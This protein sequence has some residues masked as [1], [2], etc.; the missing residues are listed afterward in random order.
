MNY[1]VNRRI[2]GENRVE[3]GLSSDIYRFKRRCA[4]TEQVN[5]LEDFLLLFAIVAIVD[6]H[7]I[8]A[9]LKKGQGGERSDVARATA[10]VRR[11][12][13]AGRSQ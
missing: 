6:D 9:V 13:L 10:E 5:A 12:K 3:V 11:L 8:I 7:D 2:L 1:A 4:T